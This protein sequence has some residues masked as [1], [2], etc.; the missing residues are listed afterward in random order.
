MGSFRRY[1]GTDYIQQQQQ[2]KS[3]RRTLLF[4]SFVAFVMTVP[5]ER[6]KRCPGK[7]TKIFMGVEW[8]NVSAR[9]KGKPMRWTPH[10]WVL[11]NIVKNSSIVAKTL[12]EQSVS[13]NMS[14]LRVVRKFWSRW[15]GCQSKQPVQGYFI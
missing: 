6:P 12:E 3:T 9:S 4:G 5:A 10:F 7:G 8:C 11:C 14:I 1:W 2:K 13:F 15:P